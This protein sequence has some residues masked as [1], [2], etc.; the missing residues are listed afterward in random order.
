MRSPFLILSTGLLIFML[1]CKNKSHSTA[2]VEPAFYHWKTRFAPGP[3]EK[4]I[5]Q[6]QNIRSLYLRFFDVAW[7]DTYQ[8]P[9]P[10]A[11]VRINEPDTAGLNHIQFIPTIF[12]TNECMRNISPE[13]CKPLA[14]KISALIQSIAQLHHLPTG[15]EI[16]I[17]CDWTASTREKYFLLLSEIQKADTTHLYSA[18]IRLFQIKYA[19]EAGVPPVKKG[20]LM[21]YNMGN[22]K[23]PATQ[24]SILDVAEV[25]KYISN[26]DNY[27]LP[28]DVALPVFDWYVLFRNGQY[29][30]LIQNIPL[31]EI[32]AIAKPAGVHHFEITKDTLLGKIL[33]QKGDRLRQENCSFEDIMQT[34]LLLHQQLKQPPGRLVLYHL[35]S[36]TLSK[37]SPH[38]IKTIFSSLH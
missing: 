4:Q 11:Q 5:L 33:L 38:E 24:N 35:D 20:L 12:I 25:K 37:Y 30:G 18:T 17:D 3:Y 16:Q 23:S 22:L 13:Q 26:L 9:I 2:H 28:L 1:S 34:T 6:Q 21:C 32:T 31:Q 10:I 19:A 7:D 29:S 27:P 14:Q 36:I 8:Q 15:N